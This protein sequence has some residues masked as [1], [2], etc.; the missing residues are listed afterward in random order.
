MS[1]II[2]KRHQQRL[3]DLAEECKKEAKRK[4]YRG[5]KVNLSGLVIEIAQALN[6]Y[7]WEV[8]CVLDLFLH[9]IINNVKNGNKE[10]MDYLKEQF[11]TS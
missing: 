3:S 1:S 10:I 8:K 7:E 6:M 11:K 2:V 5:E 4:V 9:K